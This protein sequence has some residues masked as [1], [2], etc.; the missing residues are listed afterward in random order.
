MVALFLTAYI[1]ALESKLS[2]L[3]NA[4]YVFYYLI[5]NFSDWFENEYLF[6]FS[7]RKPIYELNYQE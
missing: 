2:S 7:R 6:G 3:Y 4:Q 1:T 5:V